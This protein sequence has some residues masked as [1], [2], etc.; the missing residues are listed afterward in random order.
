MVELAFSNRQIGVR[1]L[2][3]AR[4]V[5]EE[6]SS[7]PQSLASGARSSDATAPS[8]RPRAG[9]QEDVV[10]SWCTSRGRGA[11]RRP[12]GRSSRGPALLMFNGQHASLPTR[13]YRFESGVGLNARL[14]EPGARCRS[15]SRC[16][17]ASAGLCT[18]RPGGPAVGLDLAKVEARVRFPVRAPGTRLGRPAGRSARHRRG[19]G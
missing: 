10:P 14:V 17:P 4:S 3:E 13:S 7:W 5:P 16:R 15:R 2:G 8:P 11:P 18:E 9:D 12:R 19:S 1:F 6:A